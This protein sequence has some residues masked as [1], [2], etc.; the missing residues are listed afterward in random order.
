MSSNENVTVHVGEYEIENNTCENLP[1]VK[2]D[3]KLNFVDHISELCKKTTGKLN[4]LAPESH[5]S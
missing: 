5:H 2:L 4:A 3:W 1:G